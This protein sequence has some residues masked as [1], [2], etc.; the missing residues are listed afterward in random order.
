MTAPESRGPDRRQFIALGLG[1]FA[2]AALPLAARRRERLVRR[3][4]P[5]MG[6]VAELAVVH[7]DE[8]WAQRAIDAA[9][10]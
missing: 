8:R 10:A 4:L 9:L 5:V 3:T 2:V 1:A 6:T 7:R